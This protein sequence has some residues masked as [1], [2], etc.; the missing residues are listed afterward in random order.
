[1]S[2][3]RRCLLDCVA[4]IPATLHAED[5][6]PRLLILTDIGGDPDDTQSMIR[7]MTYA[8]EFEIEGLIAS[9]A[10]V[11]GELK[12]K[13]TRPDLIRQVVE[14]YG[15]VQPNLAR[16]AEGYPTADQLL[17]RITS[18]N[19]QRGLDAI[20]EGHD[21]DGSR[22]IIETADRPDERPLNI[23][24]WGGQTDLAQALWC[25]RKDRTPQELQR[26]VDSLRIYDI[27]DQDRIQPWIAENF[28]DLFYIL[29]NAPPGEDKRLGVF[30]GMYLGGDESLTSREWIDRHVRIDHGPLGALYPTKTWTAPNP[31][32]VLK[33]GDT[34]S[35][36][37]FLPCGLNNPE[38]PEWGGWGGRFETRDGRLYRDARDTVGD[39]TDGRS[40]VSRWRP[41][42]QSE[43]QAR[44]DW[45]V[46]APAE[47]NHAP[48]PFGKERRRTYAMQSSVDP[49][50][51]STFDAGGSTD[52]DNDSLSYRW[53]VYSEAG[54]GRPMVEIVSPD[55]PR[56]DVRLASGKAGDQVHVVLEVTDDG[57]PP[58]TSFHR[59]VLQIA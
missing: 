36:F 54:R 44:M 6:R 7:L 33:E 19:P 37:Y 20:G 12:E 21:T 25:V 29:G 48:A 43:F 55:E 30:R 53:W 39:V 14:A 11:P 47:A 32:G 59:F 46:K 56:T 22:W 15:K 10:G 57:E 34:P 26:F 5:L 4:F 1:V 16:H 27:A 24:I 49:D 23:A 50:S 38:H 45:C 8:N 18:G 51:T 13:I 28:R 52:P 31:H 58:L 42:F 3:L 41:A 40:T 2:T 35:W 9:A 17:A